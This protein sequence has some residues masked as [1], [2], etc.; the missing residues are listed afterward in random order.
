[1]LMFDYYNPS[2]M[3]EEAQYEKQLKK[4]YIQYYFDKK[5]KEKDNEK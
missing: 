5:K 2:R 3:K 1:M 4:Q